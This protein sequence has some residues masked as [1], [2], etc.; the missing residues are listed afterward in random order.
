MDRQSLGAGAAAA[1]AEKAWAELGGDPVLLVQEGMAPAPDRGSRPSAGPHGPRRS[2][3]PSGA[4]GSSRTASGGMQSG[5]SDVQAAPGQGSPRDSVHGSASVELAAGSGP[6]EALR[7]VQEGPQEGDTAE[8]LALPA[9]AVAPAWGLEAAPPSFATLVEPAPAPAL[10][11][12]HS[13]ATAATTASAN[14]F[15]AAT[16][17]ASGES[18]GPAPQSPAK[19][20]GSGK[21]GRMLRSLLQGRGRSSGPGERGG[22]GP[23]TAPSSPRRPGSAGDGVLRPLRSMLLSRFPTGDTLPGS[24]GSLC[25]SPRAASMRTQSSAASAMSLP[26]GGDGGGGSST[27]GQEPHAA[28]SPLLLAH[29]GSGGGG[30]PGSG[31]RRRTVKSIMAIVKR[32]LGIGGG[33]GGGDSSCSGGGDPS[34]RA[35]SYGTVSDGNGLMPRAV[36]RSM[37]SLAAPPVHEAS[38]VQSALVRRA[39]SHQHQQQQQQQTALLHHVHR[40]DRTRLTH[41]LQHRH[42]QQQ[43]RS[44]QLAHIA[45]LAAALLAPSPGSPLAGSD[46]GS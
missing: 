10:S 1:A 16:A 38:P 17:L 34:F 42:R 20:G 35:H 3:L 27:L 36:H 23:A 18:P 43:R 7:A 9:A 11:R 13:S 4:W 39:A 2:G 8:G 21:V 15:P 32:R 26:Y 14:R 41:Q 30:A 45:P 46:R 6:G 22:G 33:L 29:G 24:S 31:S 12:Q 44:A 19:A 40:S 37:V 5:W 28:G 25:N